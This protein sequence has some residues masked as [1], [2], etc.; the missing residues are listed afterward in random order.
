[1][2]LKAHFAFLAFIVCT[3]YTSLRSSWLSVHIP[4]RPVFASQI[5]LSVR[6][7]Q[8]SV[9]T[10]HW[11]LSPSKMRYRCAL[12]KYW[13]AVLKT[14][15][16]QFFS[17]ALYTSEISSAHIWSTTL[18]ASEV[19]HCALLKYHCGFLK[20]FPHFSGCDNYLKTRINYVFT[21]GRN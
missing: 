8:R 7:C 6:T 19:P 3:S 1:M 14:S 10:S 11:S 21:G 4:Q 13:W 20:F 9:C 18:H 17:I 15:T 2:A 12:L 5:P 16:A